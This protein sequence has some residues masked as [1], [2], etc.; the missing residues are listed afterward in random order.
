[1]RGNRSS[2][3]ACRSTA[4]C[5]VAAGWRARLSSTCST[6]GMPCSATLSN[7]NQ[8]SCTGAPGPFWDPPW[9]SS[10][11]P[12]LAHF[13]SY[14]VMVLEQVM[15]KGGVGW[16]CEHRA[17][18]GVHPWVGNMRR[19]SKSSSQVEKASGVHHRGLLVL[20]AIL[21]ARSEALPALSEPYWCFAHLS[22]ASAA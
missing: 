17:F 10:A 12:S 8:S 21:C 4:L 7:S 2:T 9:R 19:C 11:H 15:L 16:A 6:K 3:A 1:M 20:L 5:F 13:P 14:T 22:H 18:L